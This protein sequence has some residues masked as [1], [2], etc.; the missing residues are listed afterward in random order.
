MDAHSAGIQEDLATLMGLSGC[1][2]L[3]ASFLT[4]VW[5]KLW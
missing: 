4:A 1:W 3:L 5:D 2:L